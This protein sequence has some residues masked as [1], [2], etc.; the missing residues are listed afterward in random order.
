MRTSLP[1]LVAPGQ[2]RL[3][4]L[5]IEQKLLRAAA[6][7]PHLLALQIGE[8]GHSAVL[9]GEDARAA[10]GETRDHEHGGA[11][12]PSGDRSVERAGGQ[13]DLA[14]EDAGHDVQALCEHALFQ[15]DA[16]LGADLFH[17]R[18]GAIVRELE[19]AEADHIF[20]AGCQGHTQRE[21]EEA[22]GGAV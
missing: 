16:V 15:A 11:G 2:A 9:A 6:R 21:D 13:I 20:A 14:G 4:Q 5:G 12:G 10:F 8:P 19:V 17:V 18:D 7:G 3:G 1:G 22:H